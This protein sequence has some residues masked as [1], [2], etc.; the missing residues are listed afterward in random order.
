M[1]EKGSQHVA[2]DSRDDT[3]RGDFERTGDHPPP[4]HAPFENANIHQHVRRAEPPGA[5]S[6]GYATTLHM[7]LNN[8]PSVLN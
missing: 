8:T 5:T 6:E 1:R 2:G 4:R 7:L 3:D